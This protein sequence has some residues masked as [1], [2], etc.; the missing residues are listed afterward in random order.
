[1]HI[2]T[3]L[4]VLL[5]HFTSVFA[6]KLNIVAAGASITYGLMSSHGNGYRGDVLYSLQAAGHE[7]R[8]VGTRSG[9]DCYQPWS[10]GY[11]GFVIDQLKRNFTQQFSKFQ[12]PPNVIITLIGTNDQKPGA[13]DISGAPG[14]FN[15]LLDLY[16][17]LCPD[18]VIVAST[19]PP[20]GNQEHNNNINSYNAAMKNI[21]A[22]RRVA[23]QHI[24]L[25]DGN[26][27]L[28]IAG[29]MGS[30]QYHPNDKGYT[31]IG[32]RMAG[33]IKS[34]VAMGWIKTS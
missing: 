23:G 13:A 20:N 16:Q 3:P 26:T 5:L 24:L 31:M 1:M 29:E 10:E 15:G 11:P 7:V 32:Q 25:N 21:I 4:A 28:S 34:A 8:M 27:G 19:L 18:C 14:R 30:D 6:V 12:Y 9:G 22:S 2:A 17:Y 33:Q